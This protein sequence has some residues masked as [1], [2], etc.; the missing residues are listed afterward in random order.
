MT[1][2]QMEIKRV[3]IR[4]VIRLAFFFHALVGLLIG[5]L[6]TVA[7]GVI[8]IFGMYD[9]IPSFVGELGEPSSSSILMLLSMTAGTLGVL[10]ALVWSLLTLLYN[11]IAGIAGGI[12]LR[13]ITDDGERE[14]EESDGE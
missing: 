5:L 6:L 14:E 13:A 3:K 9:V 2:V 7:W 8:G 11:V 12:E 1:V 10:G 4:S